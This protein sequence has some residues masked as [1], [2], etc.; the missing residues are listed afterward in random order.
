MLS[1]IVDR[2]MQSGYAELMGMFHREQSVELTKEQEGALEPEGA[3][4]PPFKVRH[5]R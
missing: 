4:S 3:A 1:T 5:Q 2:T